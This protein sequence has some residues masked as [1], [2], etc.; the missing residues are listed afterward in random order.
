MAAM[1]G[2]LT[3][4]VMVGWAG[5]APRKLKWIPGALLAVTLAT[6]IAQVLAMP[7]RFVNLPDSLFSAVQLPA[8]ANFMRMMEPEFIIASLTLAFVASAETLLSATAVDQM[9]DGPRANY[10]RE[11]LSQGVGNTLSGLAGG[12]PMTGVIVRSATNVAAG[13]KTR[14][15]AIMHGVW[16][17]LF[18][19]AL[20][21][22][23]RMVPT[24]SLAAVLVYTGYKLVNPDNVRRLL[25]FGG[26]PVIIYAATVIMIVATDLLLG[27]ITGLVL[28]V[29]KVLWA[30]SRLHIDVQESARGSY[31]VHVTGAATF[32]RMPRLV[33]ALNAIPEGRE[34]H[35]HLRGLMYIDHACFD[36]IGDWQRKRT[37]KGVPV[38]V[39]WQDARDRYFRSN[40]FPGIAKPRHPEPH[41]Q[42]GSA[43]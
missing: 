23:L 9:H 15:S 37:D 11:L 3:I 19:A 2:L 8:A 24:A 41:T 6:V 22:V 42:A 39:E 4:G 35:V 33:D 10:D 27:I 14:Y 13:A 38:V 43:H 5:F 30:L 20:P 31:D 21:F 29:V 1:L 18:V 7:V 34:I 12:L 36:A 28:S 16:L 17:L 40:D 26:A 32:L 25:R